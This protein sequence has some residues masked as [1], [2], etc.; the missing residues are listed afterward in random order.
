[1]PSRLFSATLA[2][3]VGFGSAADAEVVR[4][5]HVPADACGNTTIVAD[6]SGAVGQRSN[7]L[8]GPRQPYTCPFRPN[9]IVTFRHAYTGQDVGIAMLLPESTPR[10]EFRR[11]SVVYN[12]GSYTIEVQ[13][14]PDGSVESI[15]NAGVGRPALP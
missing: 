13:F 3:A 7:W 11:S 10:T 5:R 15:Y 9:Y 8:G 14:F 6:A 2:C 12:Y 4:F 1:M